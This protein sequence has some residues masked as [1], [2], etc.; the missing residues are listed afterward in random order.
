VS[1]WPLRR[2]VILAMLA[3]CAGGLSLISG[4]P[5]AGR[6]AGQVPAPEYWPTV[7]W[8]ESTPERQGIDSAGLL[9][10]FEY[11]REH[12]ARVHSVLIIRNGFVVLDASFFPYR[13]DTV[14]DLASVTKS[15]TSTVIGAAIQDGKITGVDVPALSLFPHDQKLESDLRKQKIT[16]SDLLTMRSG[17]ACETKNSEAILGEMMHSADWVNFVLNLPMQTDPGTRF[18][19]CSGNYHI[20]SA[21]ISK[22]TSTSEAEYARTALF[23]PLGIHDAVWPDDPNG[24]THGWGDLH[25][26]PR[27]TAKIGFLWLH[28]G[29]W[30]GKR[31]LAET[32]VRNATAALTKSTSRD[33]G[34]GYGFW[35]FTGKRAGEYEALG[36]GGQRLTVLPQLNAIVVLTGSG[37]EPDEIGGTLGAAVKSDHALPDNPA[38]VE[39]LHQAIQAALEPPPAGETSLLSPIAKAISG[40]RF[41][42]S[43]NL[44]D[45][46]SFTLRFSDQSSATFEMTV[47]G[48]R[49]EMHDV[50]LNQRPAF[51]S[52]EFGLPVALS[53][54]WDGDEFVLNYDEVAN[55]HAYQIRMRFKGNDVELQVS[56]PNGKNPL[57]IRGTAK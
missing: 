10:L 2:F 12:H 27:D 30:D 37:F 8:R 40:R 15:V 39:K 25:L 42:L 19:Y 38:A 5:A 18:E 51:S 50:S 43:A 41:N 21:I 45:L 54:R 1:R 20:L 44:L 57:I 7:G 29:V 16:L 11:V 3:T 31:L 36:R 24:I 48:T 17:L 53:G 49:H 14:H 32:W 55:N 23:A 26:F 47:G 13:G 35:A 34:Y 28:G 56:D 22:S 9:K 52:G 46:S 4:G 33:A 6:G